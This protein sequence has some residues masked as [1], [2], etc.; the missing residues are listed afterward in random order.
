MVFNSLKEKLAALQSELK[1]AERPFEGQP[2][3]RVEPV[4]MASDNMSL[5]QSRISQLINSTVS[6]PGGA[7]SIVTQL[8]ENAR[9]KP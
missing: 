5:A 3:T 2:L 7:K 6:N 4:L 1:R 8:I 9:L